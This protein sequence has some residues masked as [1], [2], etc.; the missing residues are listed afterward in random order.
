M[1]LID[2]GRMQLNLTTLIPNSITLPPP[3]DMDSKL[4]GPD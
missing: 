4:S 2:S 1:K 3:Q